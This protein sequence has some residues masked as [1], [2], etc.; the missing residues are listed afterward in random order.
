EY[1]E[2]QYGQNALRDML[3]AYADGKQH[4]D[5][6]RDVLR[7][8]PDVLDREFDAHMRSRFARQ[9][10]AIDLESRGAQDGPQVG[11]EFVAALTG[12][13][14]ALANA[15]YDQAVRLA[16]HARALFPEYAGPDGPYLLLRD[17]HLERGDTAAAIAVL[18]GHVQHRESDYDAHL[19]LA[20]L[21]ERTGDAR[22]AAD[23]LERAMYI[24]PYDPEI[25]QRMARLYG[26]TSQYD[27]LVR[28]RRALLALN[29]VNRADA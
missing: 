19:M 25:H 7:T 1:I 27:K 17:I 12:A 11:G 22:G 15:N 5:V 9:L 21:F 14:A 26:E 16:E 23:V 3:R 18:R 29:P 13:R 10:A 6:I 20:D 8:E 28:E 24:H 4:D 2:Q